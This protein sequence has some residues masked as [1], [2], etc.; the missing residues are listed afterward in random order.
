EGA[1]RVILP[2][3]DPYVLHHGSLGACAMVYLMTATAIDAEALS[4]RIG[5]LKGIDLAVAHDAA[6]ERFE[7]PA[8]RTGDVVVLSDGDTV[9]GTR[10]ADHDLSALDAP[11]RSHGGRSEQLVPMLANRTIDVPASRRLRN[12]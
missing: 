11:L 8:D 5:G 12:F 3:T 4:R 6:C 7:L 2:I 1:A 9:I 10:P